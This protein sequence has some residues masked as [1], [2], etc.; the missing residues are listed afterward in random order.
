MTPN[1]GQ[2]IKVYLE[3]HNIPAAS[4]NQ[5]PSRAKRRCIRRIG[6]ERVSFPMYPPV[7]HER[8]KV[9]QRIKE[10]INIGEE[11]ESSYR[12][13]SVDFEINQVRENTINLSARKIHLLEIRK[14]I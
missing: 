3:E 10:E 13:Y 7:T 14:N 9:L 11:V 2:I 6:N 1:G 8:Q 12:N 4:V 5:R